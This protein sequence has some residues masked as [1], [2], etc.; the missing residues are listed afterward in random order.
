M[1]FHFLVVHPLGY[2]R[3]M[4]SLPRPAADPLPIADSAELG[5]L[6]VRHLKRL[7]SRTV[8]LR[9]A[10]G[11]DTAAAEWDADNTLLCGLALGLHETLRFLYEESPTFERFEQ[12]V[13]A[14][15]GGAL[16]PARIARINQALS[17]ALPV[18]GDPGA[19]V[20][21]A[22]DLAFFDQ[23]GYVVLP[24]AIPPETCSAAAA[25]IWEFVGAR[26]DRPDT[27]YSGPQGHSIWV[28]LLRH[29]A[30][31]AARA[32]P[33]IFT[34]FAQLWGRTDLWVNVDQAGFNPP[35]RPGWP[36]PGPL[37]HWDASL[38]LPIHFG[39]Q[40]I[41]YLTHTEAQ[42][43][44]FTCVPGFHRRIE[45]WLRNLPPGAD[46]R[47]QDLA[48]FGPVPIAGRAG[49]LIVWHHALPHGSSPNRATLPRIVQYIAL[50]PTTTPRAAT[51]R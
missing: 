19:P 49:D 50:R 6:G 51:W 18:D 4:A 23:H 30:L 31:Q 32:S 29:P 34:A 14:N 24:G 45:D 13:L 40:G 8:S 36:F 28:P 37:L 9:A 11:P 41:L 35:E 22:T 16:H 46:P 10:P 38:E 47:L 2:D 44:A 39:L 43:G 48:S 12:W 17:G 33:R 1:K 26:P 20:L 3:L 21:T 42:Q 5:A 27:W 25:A 7:W 15:N